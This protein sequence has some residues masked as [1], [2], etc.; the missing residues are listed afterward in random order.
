MTADKLA[1]D[2]VRTL[3]EYLVHKGATGKFEGMPENLLGQVEVKMSAPYDAVTFDRFKANPGGNS[4]IDFLRLLLIDAIA[5]DSDFAKQL[6]RTLGGKMARSARRKWG[7]TAAAVVAVAALG[8]VYVLGRSGA[9]TPGDSAAPETPPVTVTETVREAENPPTS[10]TSPSDSSTASTSSTSS[11]APVGQGIPGD[12]STYPEG[13]PVPLITLPRPNDE[14][15]FDH[16][17]H[18]VQFKQY[19]NSLWQELYSCNES[20]YS[21]EQQFRLTNFSRLEVKAVGTDSLADPGLV[22]Q[23]EVFANNDSVNPI[24][25]VVANPGETKQVAVDLPAGVFTVTL[26]MSLT[27][28]GRPCQRGNAV[29][30]EPYVIATGN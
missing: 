13:Q 6:A 17:D 20:S 9:D 14:W 24:T 3:S 2:V 11:T 23:F 26:R 8:G 22:V 16:G 4:E 5:K 29:W 21:R 12:G 7:S 18:D 10:S 25:S 28:G 19:S 30:G 27:K 1:N 15:H